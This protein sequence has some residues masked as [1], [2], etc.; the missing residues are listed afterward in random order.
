MMSVQLEKR[1][2]LLEAEVERLK[3][4]IPITPVKTP[5]PMLKFAGIFKDDS[6]FAAVVANIATDRADTTEE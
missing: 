6:D 4:Q 5:H 1:V 2:A 3:H